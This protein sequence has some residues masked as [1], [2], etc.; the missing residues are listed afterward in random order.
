M[1]EEIICN[2]RNVT[3]G[4]IVS[5]I[6]DGADTVEKIGEVTQA[7]TGCSRCKSSIENLIVAQ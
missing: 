7:G 5:A 3:T 4:D 6:K 1:N 2:C